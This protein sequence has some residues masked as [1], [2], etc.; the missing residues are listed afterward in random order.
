LI[1]F[2][3]ALELAQHLPVAAE[4]GLLPN[5]P[6]IPMNHTPHIF[7]IRAFKWP[8]TFDTIAT[9]G[10]DSYDSELYLLALEV[11]IEAGKRQGSE[12][13]NPDALISELREGKAEFEKTFWDPVHGYYAYTIYPVTGKTSTLLDTFFAQHIAERLRLPDL[14][15]PDHYRKQLSGTYSAFMSWSDRDG[16]PVG[17]PNMLAG[18]GVKEW[19]MLGVLGSV[20]EEGVW[21]GVNYFV[22]STYVA[23]GKRFGSRTL[24]GDGIS[25]GSAVATQAWFS[26]K[27]GYAFNVPMSWDRADTTWYI[28]PAYERELAIWDLM[29]SIKPFSFVH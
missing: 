27:N 13:S 7:D 20:Q 9:R 17:A 24:I 16:K 4:M 12:A 26:R 2:A 28:Y 19:P 29:E 14:V 18:R 25:M 21:P 22:A 23:A 10:P 15:D 3:E 6:T 11:T 1:A 5:D 8:N